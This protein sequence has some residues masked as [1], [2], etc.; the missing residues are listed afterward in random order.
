MDTVCIRREMGTEGVFLRPP[1]RQGLLQRTCSQRYYQQVLTKDK[2]YHIHATHTSWILD[3]KM[4]NR[5]E[6]IQFYE[7]STTDESTRAPYY[8]NNANDRLLWLGRVQ[9]LKFRQAFQ[10]PFMGIFWG[11]VCK[12]KRSYHRISKRRKAPRNSYSFTLRTETAKPIETSKALNSSL[13]YRTSIPTHRT[14]ATKAER[15]LHLQL[16]TV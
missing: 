10:L 16:T 9:K 8:R 11:L 1:V 6:C 3:E 4:E 5:S 15:L 14:P 7:G 12:W 13:Q 2:C